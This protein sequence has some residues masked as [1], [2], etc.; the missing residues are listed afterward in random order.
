MNQNILP[1]FF[2]VSFFLLFPGCEQSS[3]NPSSTP[4]KT[5]E[6]LINGLKQHNFDRVLSV[7]AEDEKYRL[8]SRI[9]TE[10]MYK[11]G[12][13]STF[14]D[15]YQTVDK[16][17]QTTVKD[18]MNSLNEEHGLHR[19]PILKRIGIP[20]KQKRLKPDQLRRVF[21]G[22][23]QKE[24][25]KDLSDLYRLF[26]TKKDLVDQLIKNEIIHVSGYRIEKQNT[27]AS[28]VFDQYGMAKTITLKRKDNHWYVTKLF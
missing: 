22:V 15:L 10:T 8:I 5:A 24:L 3:T 1:L 17:T 7:L 27:R 26:S 19:T 2:V 9:Y 25:L 18:S 11:A 13:V 4:E 12:M 6:Y 16:Q 20:E 14:G 28:I 21:H 23:D